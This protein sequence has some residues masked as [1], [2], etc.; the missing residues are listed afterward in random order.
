ML[1]RFFP[2][3]LTRISGGEGDNSDLQHELLQNIMACI[4]ADSSCLQ[5]WIKIYPK[6]L[7]QSR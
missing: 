5:D 3:F 1:K 2:S 4:S 7:V 6:H